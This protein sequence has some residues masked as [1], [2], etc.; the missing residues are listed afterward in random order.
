MAQRMAQKMKSKWSEYSKL[1]G[2]GGLTPEQAARG[3][4]FQ[5]D[6]K[7]M[8]DPLAETDTLSY[9]VTLSTLSTLFNVL[10][11]TLLYIPYPV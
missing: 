11:C 5:P 10:Y 3:A 6:F 4:L 8:P 2:L 9:M 1:V 7:D